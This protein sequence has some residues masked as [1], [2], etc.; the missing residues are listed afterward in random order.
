MRCWRWPPSSRSPPESQPGRRPP[1]ASAAAMSLRCAEACAAF[2][3]SC[4]AG[5]RLSGRRPVV[6]FYSGVDSAHTQLSSGRFFGD[7]APEPSLDPACCGRSVPEAGP[8]SRSACFS[9]QEPRP[10]ATRPSP[11]R[12]RPVWN[13]AVLRSGEL[14]ASRHEAGLGEPPE[15]DE[16][17]AGERHDHHPADPPAGPHSAL[18]E[19]L[20]E[21]AIRLIAQPAPRHLDELCPDPCW[22]VAADPLVALRVSARPRGW[23]HTDPARFQKRHR[24]AGLLTRLIGSL[25]DVTELDGAGTAGP[26]KDS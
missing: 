26:C 8:I 7:G 6:Y 5:S 19:P 18:V 23:L 9:P 17:L 16:Q 1:H 25:G 21:R 12:V 2:R 4:P 10:L 13:S 22:T 3:A 14:G 20:A 11:G 24:S 15:R